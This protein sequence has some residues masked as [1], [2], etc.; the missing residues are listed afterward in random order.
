MSLT[1]TD[2]R[3]SSTPWLVG[4]TLVVLAMFKIINRVCIQH[5]SLIKSILKELSSPAMASNAS[6]A[7]SG[8]SIPS[9]V[10]VAPYC[11][12]QE[13]CVTANDGQRLQWSAK[14]IVILGKCNIPSRNCTGFL[15]GKVI[16]Q[17]TLN[18]NITVLSTYS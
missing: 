13:S 1:V 5:G 12:R 3:T 15:A 9:V 18:K 16:Y 7:S 11:G 6:S 14:P 8:M 17:K 10:S 2:L 4:L